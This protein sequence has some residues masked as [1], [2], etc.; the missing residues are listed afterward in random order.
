MSSWLTI[1]RRINI[2][3]VRSRWRRSLLTIA[4]IAAGVTLVV[5]ISVINQSIAGATRD[6]IR[7]LAGEAE[8]EVASAGQEGLPQET[9]E[10]V[11]A[12]PGV[13]RAVPLVRTATTITSADA[14]QR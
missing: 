13:E 14:R 7:F 10:M 6:S 2:R 5:S 8:I 3:H 1:V 4:G 12:V 9:V 11:R